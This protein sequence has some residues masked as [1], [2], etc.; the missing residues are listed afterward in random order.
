MSTDKSQGESPK[1]SQ[2]PRPARARGVLRVAVLVGLLGLALGAVGALALTSAPQ[3]D[4]A[5]G[6]SVV[7]GGV[8]DVTAR[9][10]DDQQSVDAV[11]DIAKERT[12]ASPTSGVL[13]EQQCEVGSVV[14]SGQAPF[15]LDDQRVLALHLDTP[16][17]RDL[18]VG[19]KGDDVSALQSELGRLGYAGV[20]VDGAYGKITAAAVR[21][22]WND[23]GVAGKHPSIPF[24]HVVW[25]PQTQ[26][27]VA[28]CPLE[29]GQNVGQGEALFTTGGGLTSLTLSLPEG[30]V[31]GQWEAV[32]DDTTVTVPDDGVISDQ[33]FLAAFEKTRRYLG[34]VDDPSAGLKA[35]IRL[36][37]TIQVAS[38]PASALY[39]LSADQGCVMS[40]GAPL[41]VRVVA[42][43]F[44][45]TLVASDPLPMSVQAAPGE[46][47]PACG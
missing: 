15:L 30:S 13:R 39:A 4:A 47:A 12:V 45:Q 14:A 26:V 34:Y 10:F 17:W 16:L 35:D 9:A 44:G 32:V 28:T 24:D 43:E 20:D 22:L 5:D 29:I 1:A 27:T 31:S 42:S 38:V 33:A 25:L 7:V 37:A 11:P 18:D 6:A 41:A 8:V 3:S 2:A 23:A 21:H 36:V 19:A 46:D 40:G